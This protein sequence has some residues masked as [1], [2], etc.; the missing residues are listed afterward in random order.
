[1]RNFPRVVVSAMRCAT[2]LALVAALA[3][4]CSARAASKKH[5]PPVWPEKYSVRWCGA[6]GHGH[7][8]Q[9]SGAWGRVAPGA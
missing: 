7:L 5:A 6:D 1:M 9:G 8:V 3:V 2:V 4:G